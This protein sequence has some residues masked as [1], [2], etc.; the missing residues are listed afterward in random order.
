MD[1]L[2]PVPGYHEVSS[3]FADQRSYGPHNGIDIPAPFVPAVAVGDGTISYKG[4]AGSAGRTVWLDLP[5]YRVHYCH[6]GSFDVAV[7]QTV[8][9]GDVIGYVGGSGYEQGDYYGS[10]LHLNLFVKDVRDAAH[11][12]WVPWVGMWAVDP[13]LYLGV[14]QPEEDKMPLIVVGDP[15]MGMFLVNDS[16][17]WRGLGDREWVIW[18]QK[19]GIQQM[20]VNRPGNKAIE[21]AVKQSKELS[22]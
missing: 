13:L 20:V 4:W 12:H 9:A 5:G 21:D 17:Q 15:P 19:P 16:G 8:K 3:G 6:L 11:G 2:W 7:Y 1:M 22:G 18:S 14:A 10:H